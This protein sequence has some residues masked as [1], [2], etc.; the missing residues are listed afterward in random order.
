MQSIIPIIIK[1]GGH[2]EIEL[3]ILATNYTGEKIQSALNKSK[4]RLKS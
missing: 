2:Q 1:R 3:T 4:D